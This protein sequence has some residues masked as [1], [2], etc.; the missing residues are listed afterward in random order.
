MREITVEVSPFV[1]FLAF[2]I[3]YLS[4]PLLLCLIKL[5]EQILPRHSRTVSLFALMN[6]FI[7]RR[8]SSECAKLSCHLCSCE[9]LLSYLRSKPTGVELSSLPSFFNLP[10][11]MMNAASRQYP[12]IQSN[13]KCKNVR[14]AML[15]FSCRRGNSWRL[16]LTVSIRLV[17]RF[18]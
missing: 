4:Q 12:L 17:K 7:V 9:S 3:P 8:S 16:E 18:R 5:S 13:D 11:E 15:C 10:Q 2:V 14:V 1:V 6:N